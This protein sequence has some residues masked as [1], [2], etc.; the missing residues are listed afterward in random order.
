MHTY[1]IC[2]QLFP[3]KHRLIADKTVSFKILQLRFACLPTLEMPGS[4]GENDK[5]IIEAVRIGKL[6]EAVVDRAA[7]RILTVIY[8]F[9]ENREPDAVFDRDAD[10]KKAAE[11]EKECAVLLENNGV[12]PLKKVCK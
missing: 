6:D 7:E 11:A 5:L 3:F 12:L 2:F 4:D 1:S 8:D 10:H 9:L